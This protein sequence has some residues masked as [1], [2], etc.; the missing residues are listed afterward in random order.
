MD[1]S[2]F[3][4]VWLVCFSFFYQPCLGMDKTNCEVMERN[5]FETYGYLVFNKCYGFEKMNFTV[6]TFCTV[7]RLN[8]QS[9]LQAVPMETDWLCL[10][11][12]TGTIPPGIFSQ[13]TNL[14]HLYVYGILH[15]LS[16]SFGVLPHLSTLWIKAF[17]YSIVGKVDLGGFEN[18]QELKLSGIHFSDLNYSTFENL[19]QLERLTLTR[20][21]IYFLSSVTHH[22]TKMKS[23]QYLFIDG[24]EIT[25]LRKEDCLLENSYLANQYVRLNISFLSLNGF[26]ITNVGNNS[27]CNFPSLSFFK[28]NIHS[29]VAENLFYS[30]IKKV[31]ILSFPYVQFGHLDICLYVSFFNI[32][33]FQLLNTDIKEIDTSSGSC[34]TLRLLDVSYN[35]IQKVSVS[36]VKKLKNLRDLNISNNQITKLDICPSETSSTKMELV[37]LN[38]SFNYIKSLKQGQFACLKNLKVLVLNDNKIHTIKNCTFCG[39]DQL[40]VLKLEYNQIYMIREYDFEGLYSLKQLDLFEN[41]L[42]S[43]DDWAFEDLKK[44]EE[45]TLTFKYNLE[46]I[47][48]S[49]HIA[50]SLR[51]LTLKTNDMYI[52]LLQQHF[53]MFYYLESLLIEATHIFVDFC[54]EFPFYKV[55]ELKLVNNVVFRCLTFE[56][57][58]SNFINLEK[59]QFT[60]KLD[61]TTGMFTLNSTLIHLTKLEYFCLENTEKLVETA[62]INSDE[63]FQGLV[64]LNILH[65]ISSGIDYLS[66]D[67][68]FKD[69]KSLSFLII[70]NQQLEELKENVFSPMNNLKY[71][72]LP[73]TSIVCS[74]RLMWLNQ[75]LSYNK[76]VSFIDF[77]YQTCFLQKQSMEINLVSFLEKNCNFETEFNIFIVTFVST[78]LFMSI[79]LFHESIWWYT[80]YLAYKFKCW[81]NHRLREEGNGQYQ[82]DVFVSYNTYDEQWVAEQLLPKLEQNGPPFFRVCIHNRDFEIGRDIV[83][84]VV[85]SICKSRWTI[86]LITRSYLQSHWCSLEMRMATY[87]L[88]AQRTDSLILIFLENISRE[89][90][91]YYHRLTKLL[92]KKTYLDWP[93]DINGQA[94]FWA[95]LRKVICSYRD[96]CDD[97]TL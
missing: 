46:E 76:Q 89:E 57:A 92:D 96:I 93:D 22:L 58:L 60:S 87:R 78:F 34:S 47:W 61:Q 10:H 91:Q 9:S 94:L 14:K 32:E 30:G 44:L 5:Y 1:N 41:A 31:N 20:N 25:E 42:E 86:C 84:N 50:S 88:L 53:S 26:Q 13:F 52:T 6:A 82:Y 8:L 40:E 74:C 95:R 36:Q 27:L 75:W 64:N 71:I 79:T 51:K 11:F 15:L 16:E 85:D 55:K 56:Q 37:Y 70:E 21:N 43:V 29:L 77:Y 73:A 35:L 24:N 69:L 4:L 38:V 39:L 18:L 80:M 83:E 23:L 90:L 3:S 7:D 33:E 12:F 45:I 62:L 63:L 2:S 28:V 59:L 72:Y 67:V 54:E 65:L 19:I 97:N 48:W 68:M 66:S 17:N 49:K 81:L